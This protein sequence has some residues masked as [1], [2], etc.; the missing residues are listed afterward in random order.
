MCSN[1]DSHFRFDVKTIWVGRGEGL[2]VH[3]EHSKIIRLF[4]L[5]SYD[6]SSYD[7]NVRTWIMM[8]LKIDSPLD[9]LQLLTR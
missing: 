3:C 4:T 2:N 9:S 5:T 8:V 1:S 7:F 6:C